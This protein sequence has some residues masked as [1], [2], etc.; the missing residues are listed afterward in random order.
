MELL[1][2]NIDFL[3]DMQENGSRE[4]LCRAAEDVINA[5]GE[6][7][8]KELASAIGTDIAEM[9]VKMA[10]AVAAKNPYVG[11]VKFALDMLNLF[12]GLSDTIVRE[13]QM[14]SYSSMDDSLYNL[15]YDVS[16]YTGK[17]QY[18]PE[19]RLYRYL[20][21]L[22]QIR[23]LGEKKY[24]EFYSHGANSWLVDEDEI[25]D[26]ID[27]SIDRIKQHSSTMNLKLDS[28]L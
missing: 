14:L 5:M 19:G 12:T 24:C 16:N 28:S 21:H 15:I 1:T 25:A 2:Q 8:G 18:D 26:W 27:D 22:A 17:H 13:Y 6:G 3:Y 20:V 11:A 10:I 23:I 9:T 4:A 7:F